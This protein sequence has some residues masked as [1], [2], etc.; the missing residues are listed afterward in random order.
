MPAAPFPASFV[1]TTP[2]ALSMSQLPPLSLCL[3]C[4]WA[5]PPPPPL[6]GPPCDCTSMCF[7]LSC[8]CDC[9]FFGPILKPV[10]HLIV[11]IPLQVDLLM[12]L[13]CCHLAFLQPGKA[14]CSR[15]SIAQLQIV[16]IL[17]TGDLTAA[18]LSCL[19]YG[20]ARLSA[21]NKTSVVLSCYLVQSG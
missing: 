14:V 7:L 15:L 2:F 18:P 8:V 16:C 17:Q 1:P 13:H 5:P 12:M 10:H 11:Q 6:S 3:S 9:M 4:P 20:A 19:C 21:S